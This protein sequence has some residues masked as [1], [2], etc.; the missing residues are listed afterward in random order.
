[1]RKYE[2]RKTSIFLGVILS[3]LAIAVIFCVVVLIYGGCTNMNFVEVLQSWFTPEK[4][5]AE[6]VTATIKVLGL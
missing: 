5:V 1:M 6:P 3:L 2:G 4:V